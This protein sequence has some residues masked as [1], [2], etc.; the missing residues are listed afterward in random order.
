MLGDPLEQIKPSQ[1][2]PIGSELLHTCL[3]SDCTKVCTNTLTGTA[4]VS[5]WHDYIA[6]VI[7]TQTSFTSVN[8]NQVLNPRENH[9]SYSCHCV[10]HFD[11]SRKIHNKNRIVWCWSLPSQKPVSKRQTDCTVNASHQPE[12]AVVSKDLCC[13][14]ECIGVSMLAHKLKK[15][16]RGEILLFRQERRKVKTDLVWI[17][18]N[19]LCQ[20]I[21]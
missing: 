6:T 16:N 18:M 7:F 20:D 9:Y 5:H 10:V 3:W 13:H 17:I 1:K 19:Q 14:W 8:P 4:C 21:S 15:K 12:A 11:F 2:N